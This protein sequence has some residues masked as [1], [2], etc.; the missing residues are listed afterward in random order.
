MILRSSAAP[1]AKAAALGHQSVGR[2]YRRAL[3]RLAERGFVR[4]P[5]ETPQEFATRVKSAGLEGAEPFGQL[6]QLYVQ[7]RFGRRTVDDA[8]VARLGRLLGRLGWPL[9]PPADIQAA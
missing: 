6:V 8:E 1:V 9:R 2:A 5:S 3:E 7:A 4:R